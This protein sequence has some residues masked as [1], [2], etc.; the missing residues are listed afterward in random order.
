MEAGS[1]GEYVLQQQ[2]NVAQTCGV[3]TVQITG[4][5]ALA[6]LGFKLMIESGW[7]AEGQTLGSAVPSSRNQYI[8]VGS[9][10]SALNGAV[11]VFE[12]FNDYWKAPGPYG[13]ENSFVLNPL[14]EIN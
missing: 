2:A 12:G 13:V 9:I 10:I 7:P 3:Q 1:A 11:V 14:R 4:T 8:A 5:L 6:F